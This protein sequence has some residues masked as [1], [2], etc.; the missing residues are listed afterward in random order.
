MKLR[1]FIV[2]LAAVAPLAAAPAVAAGSPR[3]F[4]PSSDWAMEYADDSCRLVRS[5]T[6][7]GN[8]LTLALERFEPGNALEVT[9]VGNGLARFN[10]QRTVRFG[11]DPAGPEMRLYPSWSKLEDGRDW[12]GLGRVELAQLIQ[13]APPTF[14][15]YLEQ[16]AP[17]RPEEEL[18]LAR[19]ITSF[20]VPEGFIEPFVLKTGPMGAPIG[21]LQECASDLVR[22][23]GLDPAQ[24]ARL[25][26]PV[27][28]V[29]DP[30]RWS[31]TE[32][33]PASERQRWGTGLNTVRLAI[34]ATGK[35]TSCHVQRA[36]AG[37]AFNTA[38]CNL[39][40][41]KGRFRPAIDADGR[42][43]ASYWVKNFRFQLGPM[44]RIPQR[45]R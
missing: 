42:P 32:A 43:V 4:T 34:D 23:W 28:P 39:L 25:S 30:Q 6:H 9:L 18:A 2:A 37:E 33:F 16:L 20:A 15:Q 17:Y 8:V 3:Q 35:A 41:S 29:E 12:F 10:R 45:L 7:E 40:M 31:S 14:Q 21:A 44:I 27:L 19:K 24:Q 5:F 11:F 13:S 38:A 1:V 26:R 36:S 22:H